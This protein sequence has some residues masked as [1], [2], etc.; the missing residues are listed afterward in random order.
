MV[1]WAG[2]SDRDGGA[3]TGHSVGEGGAGTGHSARENRVL[4][5]PRPVTLLARTNAEL[6]TRCL[7][8]V[9]ASLQ[10]GE[11]VLK[12]AVNGKG[13]S[14]GLGKWAS[15]MSQVEHFARLWRLSGPDVETEQWRGTTLP[16]DEFEDEK[17]LTWTGM[18]ELVTSEEMT[19]FNPI[20][21]L[22]SE[23]QH[24]VTK[25]M[26][27]FKEHVLDKKWRQGEA[28]LVLSTIHSGTSFTYSP[29]VFATV[30]FVWR[31]RT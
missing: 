17:D 14:S 6:L 10:P 23:H 25:V 21:K 30:L 9:L 22:V 2:L 16:F 29:S 18:M 15:I 13:P 4:G 11:R 7:P 20:L 8:R 31:A 28:D 5:T 12:V 1:G 19:R 24:D 27:L 3:G 26:A